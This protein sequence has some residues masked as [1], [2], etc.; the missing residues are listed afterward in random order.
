MQ[1]SNATSGFN[2]MKFKFEAVKMCKS[3]KKTVSKEQWQTKFGADA[4]HC[5]CE[6]INRFT[7]TVYIKI[8]FSVA[9]LSFGWKWRSSENWDFYK[10]QFWLKLP[11]PSVFMSL[12]KAVVT[13]KWQIEANTTGIEMHRTYFTCRVRLPCSSIA[14]YMF[15]CRQRQYYNLIIMTRLPCVS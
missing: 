1:T 4:P 7:Y 6:W 11:L 3:C 12:R 8:N 2:V 10:W 15:T 9:V 13:N 5:T 14:N